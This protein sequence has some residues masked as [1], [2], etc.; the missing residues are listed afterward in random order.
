MNNVHNFEGKRPSKA[1]QYGIENIKQVLDQLEVSKPAYEKTIHEISKGD[2]TNLEFLKDNEKTLVDFREI[3]TSLARGT[4]EDA[5][6][7][8]EINR[9]L[10]ELRDSLKEAD[11]KFAKFA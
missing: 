9:R 3:V 5:S 4:V 8:K 7:A 10:V 11:E 1:E 2:L 6:A